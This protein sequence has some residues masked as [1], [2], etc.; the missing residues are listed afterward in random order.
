MKHLAP[1]PRHHP[2]RREIQFRKHLVKAQWRVCGERGSAKMV[3][4]YKVKCIKNTFYI[5]LQSSAKLFLC[6]T[7]P[8]ASDLGSSFSYILMVLD[9]GH[10]GVET[11]SISTCW[12]VV[13]S[14][15]A[16]PMSPTVTG[17][18]WTGRFTFGVSVLERPQH[19]QP[20]I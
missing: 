15:P 6:T 5:L 19:V 10:C 1:S 14:G 3:Y 4:I 9:P 2:L 13:P 16:L 17:R 8:F 11:H 12:S 20:K 18:S 7:L